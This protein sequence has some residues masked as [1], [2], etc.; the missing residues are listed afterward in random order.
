MKRIIFIL[1]LLSSLITYA[2]N[3]DNKPI[4]GVRAA[5]DVNIPG[6]WHFKNGGSGVKMYKTG[7]G[8]TVGAICNLYIGNGFYIEPGASL[9]YNTYSYDDL[10]IAEAPDENALATDPSLYKFGVRIP[11]MAG[12]T[13]GND[14]FSMS[15]YTGPEVSIALAGKLRLDDSI[16]TDA[17]D[18]GIFGPN[19]H[20]RFDLAWKIGFSVPFDAWSVGIDAAIGVTDIFRSDVIFRENR[21]SVSLTRYF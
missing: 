5:F 3:D 21:V 14:K 11:V 6:D 9:Y 13:F 16:D 19:G 17:I 10:I 18:T 4:W 7:Y 20:S 15:V 2:Q 8:A 1:T 12:Y